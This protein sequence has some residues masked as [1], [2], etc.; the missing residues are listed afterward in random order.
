MTLKTVLLIL[1]FALAIYLSTHSEPARTVLPILGYHLFSVPRSQA[2]SGRSRRLRRVPTLSY[3]ANIW[4]ADKRI[5]LKAAG[6]AM[7]YALS[8]MVSIVWQS[9]EPTVAL[10]E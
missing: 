6:S 9:A 4:Q 7:L 3:S 8:L 5:K 2:G 10:D 1:L